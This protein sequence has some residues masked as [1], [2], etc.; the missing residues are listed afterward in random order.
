M[1]RDAYVGY[2]DAMNPLS[3]TR[4]NLAAHY[5]TMLYEGALSPRMNTMSSLISLGVK[6]LRQR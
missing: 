2:D 1:L 5:L 4:L 3:L 6:S